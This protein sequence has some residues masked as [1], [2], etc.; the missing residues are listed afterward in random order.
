[1]ANVQHAA[2]QLV[3]SDYRRCLTPLSASIV[4]LNKELNAGQAASLT[5]DNLF[6]G[7]HPGRCEVVDPGSVVIVGLAGL[8]ICILWFG[9]HLKG[10]LNFGKKLKLIEP[11]ADVWGAIFWFP[12]A[13]IIV[14]AVVFLIFIF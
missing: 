1:M 9:I 2:T 13:V 12:H 8:A 5:R 3:Q 14:F 6:R 11:E 4:W 10:Y 7:L